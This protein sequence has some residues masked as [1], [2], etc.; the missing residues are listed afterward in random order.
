MLNYQR[1]PKIY[2]NFDNCQLSLALNK[3]LQ[4]F[5]K[6]FEKLWDGQLKEM[7][8]MFCNVKTLT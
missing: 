1:Q 4:L 6:K 7:Q 3:N 2:Y 5:T 8:N